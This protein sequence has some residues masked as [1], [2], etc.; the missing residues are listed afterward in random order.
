MADLRDVA[1][2]LGLADVA[3]YG[4]SGNVV[5]STAEPDHR[6]IADALERQVA[7]RTGVAC[8][9]VVLSAADLG[10]V[11][12]ANPYPHEPNPKCLHAVLRRT[13]LAGEEL[14][15][16]A[17]AERRARDK[18][19]RDELTVIGGT[20]YL[21]TPDGFGRSELAAQLSRVPSAA[22]GTARNWSTITK[23]MALLSG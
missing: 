18:G 21:W 7:A 23:V 6:S 17:A 12:A 9:V 19:S 22:A 14:P 20:I 1:A 16:L 15:A 8:G 11:I 10:E 5:F 2:G 3:T 13:D 4:Q